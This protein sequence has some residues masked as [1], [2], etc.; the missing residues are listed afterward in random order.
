MRWVT[1]NI[2]SEPKSGNI[3]LENYVFVAK[4]EN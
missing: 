3:D 2:Q 1:V 4:W